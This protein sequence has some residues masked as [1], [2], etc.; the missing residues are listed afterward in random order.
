MK[1]NEDN[2]TQ[3][4]VGEHRA[5]RSRLMGASLA[6]LLAVGLSG[7][8]TAIT[9]TI[10]YGYTITANT[11]WLSPETSGGSGSF[12]DQSGDFALTWDGVLTKD[13]ITGVT[14]SMKT[15]GFNMN[16]GGNI[17]QPRLTLTA[18]NPSYDGV[19]SLLYTTDTQGS[20]VGFAV[21][22]NNDNTDSTQLNP[23]VTP[24]SGMTIDLSE[25]NPINTKVIRMQAW[26]TLMPTKSISDVTGGMDV[27][28]T[29]TIEVRYN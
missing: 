18:T 19:S 20:P 1:I 9:I 28:G 10:P 25:S 5:Y 15:F 16:C 8:A 3:T 12:V 2:R 21:Q 11:C 4:D 24:T 29:V 14:R 22:F 6:L 7:E 23:S 26:P 17:Y 27:R 13:N